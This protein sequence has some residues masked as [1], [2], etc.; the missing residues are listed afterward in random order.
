MTNLDHGDVLLIDDLD[1]VRQLTM[2][3]PDARNAFNQDLWLAMRDALLA[4]STDDGVRC[5][6]VTG[7]PPAFTAGQDLREMAD[8]EL[9]AERARAGEEPG[10]RAFMPVL[11]GFSKPLVA[12]VNGVG[13]GIGLTMLLHC[14]LVLMGESARLKAPFVS[15]GV[16]T[17][18]SASLLLPQLVGWQEAAHLLFT[19]PWIDSAL[20]KRL[21]IAWKVVPD[22]ELIGE[23]R[24][25]AATIAAMPLASLVATKQVMLAARADAVVAARARE[26]AVFE[27]L[28]GDQTN[29]AALQSF[30]A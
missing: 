2:N 3:R 4:A 24:E 27:R 13:V 28:V 26:E 23:A 12:A 7:A 21:G 17:E 14:D 20:A 22:D 18:A 9:M 11:E 6:V 8:L 16:T 1:G 30:L 29:A 10:Y 5:V 25:L 15:L 19:E